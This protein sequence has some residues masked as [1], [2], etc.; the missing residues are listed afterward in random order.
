MVQEHEIMAYDH[1]L[2]KKRDSIAQYYAAFDFIRYS[3]EI[4]S[5]DDPFCLTLDH[6]DIA[7]IISDEKWKKRILNV[8]EEYKNFLNEQIEEG[9]NER[10]D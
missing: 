3:Q 5:I 2:E 9:I 6:T 1:L 10:L 7:I 4:R 8:I